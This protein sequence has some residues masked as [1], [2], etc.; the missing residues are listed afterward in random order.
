MSNL[1]Q[2]GDFSASGQHWSGT[3]I[4]YSD[5]KAH[6]S[7]I[8]YIEQEITLSSTIKAGTAVNVSFDLSGLYGGTVRVSVNGQLY[9][10]INETGNHD[11]AFVVNAD[12]D[13]LTLRFQASNAFSLD[14]VSLEVAGCELVDL[15]TNGDFAA[16][17]D[18]WSGPHITYSG[19]KAHV[20]NGGYIEQEITLPSAIQAGSVVN[21]NFDLS[22]MY[23]STVN[24]YINTQFYPTIRDEGH[25]E[26]GIVVAKDS[27]TLKLRFQGSNA[28]SLDN[29]KL[30]T[31]SLV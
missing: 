6:V 4:T 14:N 18:H 25:H 28:F 29:V 19:G 17:G 16:S 8:G 31:C 9:P 27:D 11:I 5:G 10:L 7:N 12:S 3:H 15:I 21:V 2:N 20:S 22:G 23:G 26:I 1:I 24:V 13:T 30:F